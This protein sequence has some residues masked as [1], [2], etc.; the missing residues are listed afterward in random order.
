VYTS[1]PR[2][3]ADCRL[4]APERSARAGGVARWRGF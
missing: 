2:S 3:G 1:E 4:E